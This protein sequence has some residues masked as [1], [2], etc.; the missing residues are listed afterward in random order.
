[1]RRQRNII[2]NFCILAGFALLAACS[3]NEEVIDVD[4]PPVTQ[5]VYDITNGG[6]AGY[7]NNAVI[8]AFSSSSIEVYSLDG[9]APVLD[10]PAADG[11]MQPSHAYGVSKSVEVYPVWDG[12]EVNQAA[13]YSRSSDLTAQSAAVGDVDEEELSGE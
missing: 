9:P 11:G 3:S 10:H 6:G 4:A 8:P 2:Q 12:Q 7:Q 5:T 1:M 13:T